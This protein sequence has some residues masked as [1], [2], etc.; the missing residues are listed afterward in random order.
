M[1]YRRGD[2]VIV[3]YPFGD[4]SGS[5]IRPALVVQA[6]SDNARMTNTIVA[7]ITKNLSRVAL[8]PTQFLIDIATPQGALTGL[9]FNSAVN[10]NNLLTLHERKLL[11]KIGR[12]S[13]DLLAK[14]N[15]CLKTAL[16]L[17]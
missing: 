16:S 3:D 10:C 14:I 11:R 13:E 9:K 1:N 17:N 15:A 12:L 5:K 7:M 6:D 2:I 4:A 8:E